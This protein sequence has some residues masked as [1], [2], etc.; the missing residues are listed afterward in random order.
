MNMISVL[1]LVDDQM[2][3]L[4]IVEMMKATDP[5]RVLAK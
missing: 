3:E 4:N 2:N 1:S 5:K